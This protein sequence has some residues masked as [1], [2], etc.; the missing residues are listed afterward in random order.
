MNIEQLKLNVYSELARCKGRA[1]LFM[2]IEGKIIE[3]NSQEVYQSASLIKIP[4]LYEALRQIEAGIIN[5]D[6]HVNIK[7]SDKIGNTGV[8]Q[9]LHGVKSYTIRDLLTLMVI[10]SDNSATNLIINLLSKE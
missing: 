1:S 6:E 7:D 8:L 9:V 10:V 5:P 3:F 4:I 2:E